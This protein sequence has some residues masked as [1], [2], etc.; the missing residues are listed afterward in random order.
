MYG[1]IVYKKVLHFRSHKLSIDC[2]HLQRNKEQK[3]HKIYEILP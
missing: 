1:K 3:E 2:S